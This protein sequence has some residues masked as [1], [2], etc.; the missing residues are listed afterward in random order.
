MEAKDS[1][2]SFGGARHASKFDD[3]SDWPQ[4][5]SPMGR[6]RS[7]DGKASDSKSY[8]SSGA[9]AKSSGGYF[10]VAEE[11]ERILE[12]QQELE[13]EEEFER[14]KSAPIISIPCVAKTSTAKEFVR[15]FKM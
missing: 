7:A 5:K 12:I 6:T 4:E 15:G 9:A 8:T 10:D 2:L 14:L 1:R 13:V 11:K 3:S